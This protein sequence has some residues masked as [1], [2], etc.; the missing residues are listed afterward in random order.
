M[1]VAVKFAYDG[2]QFHGYQRQPDIRT[3]EDEVIRSLKRATIIDSVADSRFQSGS[4]TD[5]GVSAL[6]NAIAFDT[7]FGLEDIVPAHNAYSRSV[8]FHST[9]LVDDDFNPRYAVQRWYR[10]HLKGHDDVSA[11]E[12]AAGMFVGKHDFSSFS[13]EADSPKRELDSVELAQI[14]DFT[15]VDIR[16]RS[17]LWQMVRRIVAAMELHA[18]GQIRLDAI[19]DALGGRKTD[20]GIA[21]PEPL[22][23]MDID[24]GLNFDLQTDSLKEELERVEEFGH[25]HDVRREFF[26]GLAQRLRY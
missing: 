13:K 5:R 3:V 20:F 10:Y 23:L 15:I 1:R 18:A 7:D 9:S 19:A 21:P 6:G 22:F 25:L 14:D 26:S 8:W 24:Y 16:G 11:L 2:T 4:R 12:E 17:F